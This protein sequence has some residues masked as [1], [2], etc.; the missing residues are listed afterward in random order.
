M[1]EPSRRCN[2]AYL[3]ELVA[4][5]P[6]AA[7]VIFDRIFHVSTTVGQIDPPETMRQW[8]EDYFGSVEAVK[9]QRIVKITNLVTMEGSLFNELR[10]SRPMEARERTD[11]KK[12][13]E[14]NLGDPFCKPLE[15]TP[16]DTFGRVRG[17]HS[18]TASNVAKYDGFHGVVV[19]DEHNPLVFSSEKVSDYM[20][21][22]L[23]WAHK[24]HD[25][26][27]E[28]RYFFFMWNCLWK[29]GASILH[30]HAQMTL[31]R[32]MHY[33]RVEHLRRSALRYRETHGVNYFDDL[34]TVHK[35]LG[36]TLE[37]GHTRILAYLSPIKEKEVLLISEE[38]DQDLKD[39]IYKVLRGFVERLGV[40]SFNLALY[41]RPIAEV[42]EDWNGFP[43]VVR[44]VDRGDPNNKTADIGAMELYAASVIASDPFR[45]AEALREAFT[46]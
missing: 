13:I 22:A 25:V 7:R 10:A 45:V 36:L 2:I 21:T 29:S 9:S 26:D 33:A 44:I 31:S 30:G 46:L 20:D 8:I 3:N 17:K 42:E 28:A 43:V 4:T 15:G 24:A 14:D 39:S 11:L 32:D 19:F 34:Y 23:A 1:V 40:R 6:P 38:L 35:A 37:N 12:L 27:R 18:I 16:A 41:H 5:M